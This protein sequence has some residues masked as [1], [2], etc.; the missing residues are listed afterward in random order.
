MLKKIAIIPQEKWEQIKQ[1]LLI[2]I[3]REEWMFQLCGLY[4]KGKFLIYLCSIPTLQTKTTE[5]R[6]LTQEEWEI[7]TSKAQEILAN[8]EGVRGLR[9]RD[10]SLAP[11]STQSIRADANCVGKGPNPTNGELPLSSEKGEGGD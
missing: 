11:N 10:T 9:A 1:P 2:D 8:T 5:L 3:G 6:P 4:Q 7:A